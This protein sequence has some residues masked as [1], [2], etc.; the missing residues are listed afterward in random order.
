MKYLSLAILLFMSMCDSEEI[1]DNDDKLEGQYILQNVSCYCLFENYD[2]TLNQLWFFPDKNL[3]LSKGDEYDG[4][5]ISSPNEPFEYTLI[6][7]LLT[8]TRSNREYVVNFDNDIVILTYVDDPLIAD[9]EIIYYFKKGNAKK[10]CIDLDM[11]KNDIAC[12]KE[13]DPVCGCDGKTYSNPCYA[14]NYGGVTDFSNGEC[15][16]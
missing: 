1:I 3:L 5:Y 12:T 16:N 6:D 8:L 14:I 7:G 15:L 11:I 13:Y 9:D 2:F 4:A 10:N